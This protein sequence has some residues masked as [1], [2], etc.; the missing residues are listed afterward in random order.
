MC[1]VSLFILAQNS[2]PTADGKIIYEENVKLEI[3]LEGDAAQYADL[4][5]KENKSSKVLYFNEE[6]SLYETIN[7]ADEDIIPEMESSGSNIQV[8]VSESDE[9]I[10]TD[11]KDEKRIEQKE[12]L[13]RM[14][15][16]EKE[17]EKPEWKITG[18]QKKILDYQC[19]EATYE[20]NDSTKVIGW[21]AP[22]IPIPAGP[23]QFSGLPGMLLAVDIGG[24][25]RTLTAVSVTP[26][27]VDKKQLKRPKK[28]KKVSEAEF[29][30]IVAEKMKEMGIEG[31]P[32]KKVKHA[33]ITVGG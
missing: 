21:F 25:K 11:F 15:L 5:P 32:G 28:G 1:M 31:T 9:K 3:K 33:V 16:I 18:N 14:F 6:A 23:D 29:Q 30:Q 22:S 12:F 27:E 2:N 10:F 4:I 17:W 13:S 19:M 7:K 8:Y 24:G 26:G 20:K